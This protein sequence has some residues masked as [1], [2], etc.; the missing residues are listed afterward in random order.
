LPKTF[1]CEEIRESGIGAGCAELRGFLE[2]RARQVNAELTEISL[3]Y[4]WLENMV[5]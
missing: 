2:N 1:S 3:Q 5:L 4:Q